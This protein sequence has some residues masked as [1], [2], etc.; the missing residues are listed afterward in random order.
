MTNIYAHRVT[1]ALP[2]EHTNF[3][4]LSIQYSII[5]LFHKIIRILLL[6]ILVITPFSKRVSMIDAW[7]KRNERRLGLVLERVFW[8]RWLARR[9][10]MDEAVFR[11][12]LDP[13]QPISEYHCQ[14]IDDI[15]GPV[16]RIL[17]VGSGPLTLLG[18]RHATKRLDIVPTD[19]L[20]DD[21]ARML[22]ARGVV[23]PIRTILADAQ[24]LVNQ[25]GEA[26]FDYV[27]A[28]NCID[29][30]ADPV[31]ALTQM[32]GVVKPGGWVS[33][34]HREHEGARHAHRGLH[35]WSFGLEAGKPIL[36][37]R[38]VRIDLTTITADWGIMR[39]I[40]EPL[41]VAFAV[42]RTTRHAP[43]KT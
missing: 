17:E 3:L 15:P 10:G 5:P 13:Y 32:L 40:P 29:H 23:P 34:R 28:N 21:Y 9:G 18:K 1:E 7:L 38:S 31:R 14:F 42:R 41:H 2:R 25:F 11:A 43:D 37:N 35:K 36:F 6:V 4:L 8:R 39:L 27:T 30:C 33:L 22:A 24:G 12:A 26:A 20:A 19:L 16:V